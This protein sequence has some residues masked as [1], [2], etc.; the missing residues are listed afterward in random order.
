VARSTRTPLGHLAD[1]ILG[2]RRDGRPI[3]RIAGGSE[4]AVEAPPVPEGYL[5]PEQVNE[6]LERVRKEEKDKLYAQQQKDREAR[7]EAEK[8][9]NAFKTQV[10]ELL[11]KQREREEAEAAE[12]K[13][14]EAAEKKRKE[15][16]MSARDLLAQREQEWSAQQEEREKTWQAQ[17]DELKAQ[18]ERDQAL[19]Q[20][21]REFGELQQYIQSKVT[22]NQDNLAPQLLDFIGGNTREEVDQSLSVVLAKSQQI[23]EDAQKAF[24][25]AQRNRGVG[26]GGAGP[27]GPMDVLNDGTQQLTL[28]QINNMSMAEYAKYRDRLGVTGSQRNQGMYG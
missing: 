7:E 8:Q 10:D 26:T 24:A 27:A 12:R 16:E 1:E 13:E 15:D 17:I 9:Q 14:R 28:E 4:P 21:E 5:S 2:H 6:R 18:R 23:A 3:F 25:A 11:A 20:R 22:E 19:A